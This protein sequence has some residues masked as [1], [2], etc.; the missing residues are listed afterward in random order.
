MGGVRESL[1]IFWKDGDFVAIGRNENGSNSSA[2]EEAAEVEAELVPSARA[3]CG[4]WIGVSKRRAAGG[5]FLRGIEV[6]DCIIFVNCG[7]E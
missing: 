5:P 2:A 7:L 6:M 4:V 3:I 1:F